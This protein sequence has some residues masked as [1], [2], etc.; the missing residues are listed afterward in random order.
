MS[1]ASK[2]G[3]IRKL[4]A[5]YLA[6]DRAAV[7]AAFT[8]DF[9]FTSPYDDEIDKA[10]YFERCWQNSDWIERQDLERIMVEGEAAFVT[11]RCVAKEGKSFRNTESFA[12][13][14]DR[15]SRIDVYF[16]AT[17]QNGVFVKQQG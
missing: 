11:Y 17:Y 5:A 1:A 9:R 10:T 7:E 8:D 6:N 13:A 16:G 15:I 4:F 14:G 3:I 2:T 12:F